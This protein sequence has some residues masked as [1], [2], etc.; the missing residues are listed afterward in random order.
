MSGTG[1]GRMTDGENQEARFR[2]LFI[3]ELGHVQG[4]T[5]DPLEKIRELLL[6]TY[7]SC[8]ETPVC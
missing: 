7:G 6:T 4:G 1:E 5:A 2:E 3:E 8:E